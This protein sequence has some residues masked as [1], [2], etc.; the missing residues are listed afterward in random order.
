MITCIYIYIYMHL[1]S[2]I[3]VLR[4]AHKTTLMKTNLMTYE[5]T[6]C[7]ALQ[8]QNSRH[9]EGRL[10]DCFTA[11]ANLAYLGVL[12]SESRSPSKGMFPVAL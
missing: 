10:F 3:V 12:A 8:Y 9:E 1:F 6:C 7:G 2:S 11:F 4:Y 5:N